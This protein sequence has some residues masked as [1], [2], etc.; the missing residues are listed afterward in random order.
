LR[1][2][3]HFIKLKD[4]SAPIPLGGVNCIILVLK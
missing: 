4:E 3:P 2:C 1:F